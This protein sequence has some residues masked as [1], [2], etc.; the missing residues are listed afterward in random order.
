MGQPY[1]RVAADVAI[2]LRDVRPVDVLFQ[3]EKNAQSALV[4]ALG[5]HDFVTFAEYGP[6]GRVLIMFVYLLLFSIS[7]APPG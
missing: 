5:Q 1:H 2:A 4:C 7:F 3:P 6:A